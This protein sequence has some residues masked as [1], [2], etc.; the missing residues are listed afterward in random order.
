MGPLKK[1]R[2]AGIKY[3]GPKRAENG[4]AQVSMLSRF[5]LLALLQVC[6]HVNFGQ[7]SSLSTDPVYK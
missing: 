1:E 6:R 2:E 7:L 3:Q 5:H 4:K